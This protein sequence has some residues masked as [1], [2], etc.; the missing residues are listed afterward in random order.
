MPSSYD[1]DGSGGQD[2]AGEWERENGS[3]RLNFR[4]FK[5]INEEESGKKLWQF[6]G[7]GATSDDDY[8]IWSDYFSYN[9]QTNSLQLLSERMKKRFFCLE[10]VR[11]EMFICFQKYGFVEAGFDQRGETHF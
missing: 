9:H 2:V 11:M 8:F 10:S 1:H 6:I 7:K 5:K 4:K 3:F